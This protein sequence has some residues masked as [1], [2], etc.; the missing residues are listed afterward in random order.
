M[1]RIGLVLAAW[2]FLGL[3]LGLSKPLLELGASGVAPSFLFIL[4]AFVAMCGTGRAPFWTAIALGLL[5]DIMADVGLTSPEGRAIIVGPH[6]LGFLVGT[7]LV[8]ALRGVMIRRNPLT[9]GFLACTGAAVAQVVLVAILW[10]RMLF[11]PIATSPTHE[12]LVGLG[13]ALYTGVLAVPLALILLPAATFLGL[14]SQQPRRF[15][16]HA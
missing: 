13:G 8:I 1:S 15:S 11:D 10:V 4:T 9:L 12:L 7:Q 6:A 16:R 5:A 3:D 14:P 2:V